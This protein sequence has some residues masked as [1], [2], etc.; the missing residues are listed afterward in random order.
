M[1]ELS[2]LSPE[3][4]LD[5]TEYILQEAELVPDLTSI[6]ALSQTN[7]DLYQLLDRALYNL[8]SSVEALAKDALIFT[9]KHGQEG[10]LDRL[11]SAGASLDTS[12]K[13]KHN[14]CGLLHLAAALGLT[15]MVVKLLGLPCGS[16][17]SLDCPDAGHAGADMHN[18]L[19]IVRPSKRSASFLKAKQIRMLNTPLHAACMRHD[20]ESA[21]AFVEALLRF[22]AATVDKAD[23]GGLTPVYIAIGRGLKDIVEAFKPLIQDQ[24]LKAKI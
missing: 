4:V 11:V 16:W 10:T 12:L 8:C 14:R 15:V 2:D 21:K 22:G 7:N 9:V 19:Q 6:N 24:D 5:I 13:L 3:L 1:G 20:A 18:A 17:H 23:R